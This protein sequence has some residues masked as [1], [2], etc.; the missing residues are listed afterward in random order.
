MI[1]NEIIAA[2]IIV[3]AGQK[4]EYFSFIT[5]EAFKALEEYIEFRRSCGETITGDSWLVR[6]TWKSTNVSCYNRGGLATVPRKLKSSGIRSIISRAEWEQGLR[7]PLNKW[8]KT[9]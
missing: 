9:S 1:N 6:D 4:E 3:Y 5:P 8:R 2:K 7:I